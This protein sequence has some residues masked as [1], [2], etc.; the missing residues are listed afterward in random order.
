MKNTTNIA[1]FFMAIVIILC[2]L[3]IYTAKNKI[4]ALNARIDYMYT[5]KGFN[6]LKC[7]AAGGEWIEE[8]TSGWEKT[9]NKEKG[10]W[11]EGHSVAYYKRGCFSQ[12]HQVSEVEIKI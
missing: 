2:I 1:L 7:V 11:N 4:E 10:E 5:E 12:S 9:F 6:T 8:S 3:G